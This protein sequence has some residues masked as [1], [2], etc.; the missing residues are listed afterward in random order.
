[1]IINRTLV[2]EEDFVKTIK[3]GAASTAQAKKPSHEQV[4]FDKTYETLRKMLRKNH[5]YAQIDEQKDSAS[6]ILD[7]FGT[8]V[9]K[10]SRDGAL[11]EKALAPRPFELAMES[12]NS[13]IDKRLEDKRLELEAAQTSSPMAVAD[14]CKEPLSAADEA[15]VDNR[16]AQG[17]L[18]RV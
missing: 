3:S 7:V 16:A 2:D 5:G 4:N 12:R 13:Y 1:M 14:L 10:R 17:S 11:R 9:V 6:K 8:G 18:S 15:R